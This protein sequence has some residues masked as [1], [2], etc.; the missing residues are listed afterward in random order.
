MRCLRTKSALKAELLA[1]RQASARVALVPTM[2]NLHQGHL[3]LVKAA[4]ARADRVVVTVFVNPAQFGPHEDFDRYPRTPE[5]D[6][7]ALSAAEA[8]L[9][10]MPVVSELYPDP[11]LAA[12]RV[13]VTGLKDR[14]C[15]E[16]RPGHFEGVAL[17]VLKL[18]HLVRPDLAVFGEKD[19][20]QLAIIRRLVKD[21]DLEIDVLGVP[22]VREPDGLAMSSRNQYLSPLE[23]QQ[24]ASLY[25]CLCQAARQLALGK[26][27]IS[28]VEADT[29]R[30]L[31]DAGFRVDYVRLLDED[32][33]QSPRTVDGG[34]RRLFAAGWLGQT[35]LIDNLPIEDAG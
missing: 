13:E 20:Q 4:K 23:R 32:S 2:G 33:L 30:A 24:A 16:V 15:G 3:E 35:R 27:E 10:F 26:S 34:R 29:V 19:F 31:I 28:G 22:T 25:R 14:L 7:A 9:V 5:A 8:D 11:V 12:T 21:L 17:I 6:Q 18:F 1:W